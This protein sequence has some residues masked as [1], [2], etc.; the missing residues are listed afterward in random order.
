LF[1][2]IGNRD[3]E[4]PPIKSCALAPLEVFESVVEKFQFHGIVL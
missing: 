3:G 2:E 1:L 4:G